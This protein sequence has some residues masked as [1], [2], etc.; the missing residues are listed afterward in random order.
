[1]P[2]SA[3]KYKAVFVVAET[4]NF[5]SLRKEISFE[6]T[7]KIVLVPEVTA[8]AIYTGAE[9]AFIEGNEYYSVTGGTVTDA[10]SH[11]ITLTLNDKTNYEWSDGGTEAVEFNVSVEKAEN[12]WLVRPA[13][14]KTT[15]IYGDA[16]VSINEYQSKFGNVTIVY[17]GIDNS[18][19][20][21][22]M[23]TNKGQ[24]KVTFTVADSSNYSGLTESIVFTIEGRI[25]SVPLAPESKGYTGQTLIADILTSE[26]YT[27]ENNGGI[28]AGDYSV[29]LTLKDT[30]NCKWSDGDANPIRE[31]TFTITKVENQWTGDLT[32]IGDSITISYGD[33][34]NLSAK[35]GDINIS[36][37]GVE[38][39]EYSAQTMPQ[40]V[41]SYQI[42][43]SVDESINF[44]GLTK[45]FKLVIK[46]YQLIINAPVYKD[47]VFYENVVDVA[48]A[49][50]M[51]TQAT[52]N[53]Q[54][55]GTFTY[56]LAKGQEINN[57]TVNVVVSFVPSDTI[58]FIAPINV[59]ATIKVNAVAKIGTKNYGS[60]ESALSASK[61]GDE[62][63]MIA[64]EKNA[65]IA[66]DCTIPS[67]VTLN[68]PHT[69]DS[70]NSNGTATLTTDVDIPAVNVLTVITINAGVKLTNNGTLKVA[71]ELSGGGGG[72]PFAGHTTGKT[73]KIVLKANA[74]I[75]NVGGTINLFGLIVEEQD[76]NGSQVIVNGGNLYIPYVVRD[77]GGGT[78][79]SKVYTSATAFNQFEVRNITAFVTIK[80]SANV[81]G[82]A[83]LYAGS[84]HNATTVALV[85]VTEKAVVHLASANAYL[86]TKYNIVGGYTGNDSWADGVMDIKVYGGAT[87]EP[88]ELK[89]KAS[90]L[91]NITVSTANIFFPLT[92]RMKVSVYDGIYTMA[93]LYKMMPGHVFT[94]GAGATV[95]MGTLAVYTQS[96]FY[97]LDFTSL[98]W[99]YK[100]GES[101]AKLIVENGGALIISKAVGGEITIKQGGSFTNNGS[102]SVT[103]EEGK[104]D[105]KNFLGTKYTTQNVNLTLSTK[106]E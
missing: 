94:I 59:I 74:V 68:I 69:A 105:G 103:S 50:N 19:S 67:G 91:S 27:T 5:T 78:Y 49:S 86:T 14:N 10:G 6:I 102:S 43:L 13:L 52:L 100:A 101:D 73:A 21:T 55:A 25:V 70:M 28:N 92:W 88:M 66:S 84:K 57:G 106:E 3:G 97:A 8:T 20:G 38:G 87:V 40:Q 35:F 7:K 46:P 29:I 60:I 79:M 104:Y 31:F 82:Y 32:E 4:D 1:M 71:G 9:I 39:T 90:I 23:P 16:S 12:E 36:A 96:A 81:Y 89:I 62:V 51:Q 42:T 54:T 37:V 98:P 85:S 18:Y 41:G 22:E 15:W 95:T 83:N 99:T 47:T 56:T 63:W 61:S 58:N 77:F 17:T 72:H 45:T 2:T 33:I 24:Y 11:T 80:N 64:G 26:F 65:V 48:S 76:N 34:I 53:K 93:N 75:D 30:V 44:T